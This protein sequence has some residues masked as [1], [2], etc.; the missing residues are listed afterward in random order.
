MNG[1]PRVLD[2]L[3]QSRDPAADEALVAA[4]TRVPPD[5]QAEIIAILLE[6]AT[7]AGLEALPAIYDKLV[8]DCRDWIVAHASRLFASLRANIRSSVVQTRLNTLAIIRRSGCLQLAYLAGYA[9]HDGA[10]SVRAE[11]AATLRDLADRHY[12]TY[13]ETTSVLRDAAEA[14]GSLSRPIVQ[15]LHLLREE[16]K[17]LLAA[18]R[19]ALHCYESHHRQE[20]IEAAMF[21]ASELEDSLFQQSTLKLGKLTQ[22]MNDVLAGSLS[23]RLAPFIYVALGHQEV[24][25]RILP[26]LLNCRDAA[27]FAEFIRHHW[28]ARD[29]SVRRQLQTIRNL[30]WLTDGLEAVFSLPLDAALLMPGWLLLLGLPPDQKI[31]LLLNLLLLDDPAVSRAAVW[32]LIRIDTPAA[33]LALR[34]VLDQE[35]PELATI[36]RRE[37]DFRRRR[38]ARQARQVRKDRPQAWAALLDRAGLR[39]EF[40]DFWHHLEQIH[41]EDAAAGGP[42]AV[43]Y[44]PGFVM[45]MQMKLLS[46]QPLERL[47]ALRIIIA[48]CL[49]E[50]FQKEIF[51]AANDGVAEVRAAAAT[52]LGHLGESTSRRILERALAD[53][54]PLVQVA[55]IEALDCMQARGRVELVLPKAEANDPNVRAAAARCLLRAQ[56]AEGATALMGL[57]RDDRAE[58]RCAGLWIADQLKLVSILGRLQ[59]IGQHDPDPRI[60]RIAQHVVRRLVR[61]AR[62]AQPATTPNPS[63]PAE[64]TLEAAPT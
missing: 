51:A 41:P 11:A 58:H 5:L 14:D 21:L 55:A 27:F 53:E 52:A 50:A 33:T 1:H 18:L 10:P 12:A 19:D 35:R 54:S 60:A 25:R 22:A 42:L 34:S 57:L 17:H 49:T 61:A 45:Q 9:M 30:A 46:S 3:R 62:E 32:A 7:D 44:V 56:V 28:L 4:A 20:I 26:A 8:P 59:D 47:R 29:P 43:K 6:H 40:D 39:E 31:A 24:R 16:R 37:L 48:L 13:T 2:L 64:A 15:T 36:V 63:V 38:E 23:P